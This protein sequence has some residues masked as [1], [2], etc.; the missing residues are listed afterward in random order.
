MTAPVANVDGEEGAAAHAFP[1]SVRRAFLGARKPLSR[2]AQRSVWKAC[3]RFIPLGVG[4][5]GVEIPWSRSWAGA[6]APLLEELQHHL[7][8]LL[9]GGIDQAHLLCVTQLS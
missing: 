2:M 8:R 7:G 3:R 6:L 4:L 9:G 1:D 5:A